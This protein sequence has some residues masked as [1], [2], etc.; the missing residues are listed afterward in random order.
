MYQNSD[1]PL[2]LARFYSSRAGC[3]PS[4]TTVIGMEKSTCHAGCSDDG[5]AVTG[6]GEGVGP[7]TAPEVPCPAYEDFLVG[8]AVGLTGEL[9]CCNL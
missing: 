5:R 2:Q 3:T 4:V 1:I 9:F 6:F 8:K 7:G